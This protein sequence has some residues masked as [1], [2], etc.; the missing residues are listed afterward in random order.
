M[1]ADGWWKS[2][3]AGEEERKLISF[4]GLNQATESSSFPLI[5]G[6]LL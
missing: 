2:R 4:G 6:V 3:E 1:S 5:A